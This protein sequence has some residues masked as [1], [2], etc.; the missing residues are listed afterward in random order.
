MKITTGQTITDIELDAVNPEQLRIKFHPHINDE[1]I[2][3]L[4]IGHRVSSS[5]KV[6]LIVQLS[7]ENTY[8]LNTTFFII[9]D[10]NKPDAI[11]ID[12][13]E[14]KRVR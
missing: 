11:I 8:R 2:E 6:S 12:G 4:V 7:Y 5:G 1:G 10:D 13:V 3:G 14:F 9:Q